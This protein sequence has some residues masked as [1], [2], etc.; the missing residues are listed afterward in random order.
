MNRGP[1]LCNLR[2]DWLSGLARLRLAA[3]YQLASG[4]G[5]LRSASGS[6]I[7]DSQWVSEKRELYWLRASRVGIPQEQRDAPFLEASKARRQATRSYNDQ[8]AMKLTSPSYSLPV[9]KGCDRAPSFETNAY[10]DAIQGE[11][12]ALDISIVMRYVCRATQ[13]QARLRASS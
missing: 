4:R 11:D 10:R 1:G 9:Q 5:P 2:V 8:R 6:K 7:I 13:N 3:P 12:V